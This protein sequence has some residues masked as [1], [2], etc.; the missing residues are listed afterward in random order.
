MQPVG[1]SAG[2]SQRTWAVEGLIEIAKDGKSEKARS[3]LVAIVTNMM[4]V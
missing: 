1:P 2:G 3:G 4:S